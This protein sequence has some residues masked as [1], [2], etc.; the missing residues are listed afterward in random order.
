MQI[1]LPVPLFQTCKQAAKE[2]YAAS[3]RRNDSF[4]G[5]GE[6]NFFEGFL[7]EL[8]LWYWCSKFDRNLQQPDH[9]PTYGVPPAYDFLWNGCRIEVKTPRRIKWNVAVPEQETGL[10]DIGVFGSADA[11]ATNGRARIVNLF[12]WMRSPTIACYPTVDVHAVAGRKV[13]LVPTA[14]L[15]PMETFKELYILPRALDNC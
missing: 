4:N 3:R 7:V 2:C 9:R 10:F 1:D 12:G 14:K 6:A 13:H 8:A 15:E 5:D 11:K